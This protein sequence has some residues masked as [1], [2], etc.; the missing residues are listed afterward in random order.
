MRCQ[1]GQSQ[2]T[3]AFQLPVDFVIHTVGPVYK[4]EDIDTSE[5]LLSSAYQTSLQLAMTYALTALAFPAISC[6]VF[7]FPIDQAAS[8]A[9]RTCRDVL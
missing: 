9:V 8:I 5:K 1:T 3:P 6:G 4:K 7:A 2:I